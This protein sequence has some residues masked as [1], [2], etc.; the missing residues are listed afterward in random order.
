[1]CVHAQHRLGQTLDLRLLV[2]WQ[3]L[4]RWRA[5]VQGR[6]QNSRRPRQWARLQ[7]AHVPHASHAHVMLVLSGRECQP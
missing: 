6:F 4:L 2:R 5:T 3:L 7:L 1:M